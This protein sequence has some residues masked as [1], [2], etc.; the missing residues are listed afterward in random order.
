MTLRIHRLCRVALIPLLWLAATAPAARAAVLDPAAV[1]VHTLPNGLRVVIKEAPAI[2]LVALNVWV[3]AG[4]AD[5]TEANNGVSHFLEHLMF[6]GSK[7]RGPGEFDR[8]IE[9]LGGVHQA[10]TMEDATQY[11]VVV[12]KQYAEQALA[13]L[14]DVLCNPTFPEAAVREEQ[15]IILAELA[16]AAEN[17][18]QVLADWLGRL[19]FQKHSYRLPTAGT[20]ESVRRI[21]RAMVAEFYEKHYTADNMSLVVV[22]AVKPA[23][24]LPQIEAAFGGLRPGPAPKRAAAPEPAPAKVQHTT[25]Q[26][27]VQRGFLM[28]GFRSPGMAD[29]DDVCAMDVLLYVLGERRAQSG[30]LNRELREKRNLVSAVWSDYVT[31]RDPGLVSFYAETDPDKLEQARDALLA[32]IA[33]VRETLVPDDEIQRAK[34]LLLGVYTLDNETYDGQAGTLGFYEAKDTYQFALEYVDRIAKVTAADVQRVARKY[35]AANAYSL[36]MMQPKAKGDA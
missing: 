7:T 31:L 25:L 21:T 19:S 1:S 14:G 8:E 23:E 29:K 26:G 5:E 24:I 18:E 22:G 12:A 34:Q 10:V 17:P 6:K 32:Q 9:G 16:R 28:V 4:S 27:P 15:R 2:N 20:P 30:R 36:V 11:L 13:A 35:L 3:R 33:R